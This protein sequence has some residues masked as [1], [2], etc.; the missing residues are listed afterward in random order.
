MRRSIFAALLVFGG[1]LLA[2]LSIGTPLSSSAEGKKNDQGCQDCASSAVVVKWTNQCSNSV[3]QAACYC[4]AAALIKCNIDR[5]GCGSDIAMLRKML[6][7]NKRN[8]N[9]LGTS[10]F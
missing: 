1:V 5:G 6:A 10:C 4:A 8:A 7:E 3:S 9:Q 2:L